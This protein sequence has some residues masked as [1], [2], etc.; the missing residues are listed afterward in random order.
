[1]TLKMTTAQVV[2][3]S[4]TVTNSSFQN[5]THPDDHTTRTTISYYYQL[6]HHVIHETDDKST[7]PCKLAVW[8]IK[9]VFQADQGK[10]NSF[11]L[12]ETTTTARLKGR[13]GPNSVDAQVSFRARHPQ[14][15]PC[16]SPT[17]RLDNR[18]AMCESK[19]RAY[20]DRMLL[21]SAVIRL[22]VSCFC[23]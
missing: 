8:L 23:Y 2:E 14:P 21:A 16:I 13:C 17:Q 6:D 4:V 12:F 19:L 7:T 1:M 22:Y 10:K 18:H 9:T 20:Q 3:T 5:Y 11:L 15:L